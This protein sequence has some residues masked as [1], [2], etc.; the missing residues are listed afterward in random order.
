MREN[1]IGK[2][3][4]AVCSNAAGR[5]DKESSTAGG[6]V[7]SEELLANARQTMGE[8]RDLMRATG[9]TWDFIEK[10]I[11]RANRKRTGIERIMD[12]LDPYTT[13]P[14]RSLKDLPSNVGQY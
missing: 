10:E 7:M 8:L 3:T 11:E 12:S 6:W 5:K 14:G 13:G 2:N 1:R 4:A 9:I